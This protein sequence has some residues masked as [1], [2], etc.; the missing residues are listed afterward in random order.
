M[1][2][3]EWAN[4]AADDVPRITDDAP[5]AVERRGGEKQ[6]QKRAIHGWR[7]GRGEGL[8]SSLP[9]AA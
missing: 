7:E 1:N 8:K 5:G 9:A 3:V 2:T 6:G 4:S